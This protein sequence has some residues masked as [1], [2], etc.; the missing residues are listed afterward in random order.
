MKTLSKFT[1]LNYIGDIFEPHYS[2]RSV[3]IATYKVSRSKLDIKLKFSKVNESSEYAGYWFIP[4]KTVHKYRRKFDN[5]GLT[6]Y[7]V[8]MSEFEP[9]KIIE[10]DGNDIW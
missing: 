8:P 4:K 10:S 2:S 3:Y 7:V 6:C 1:Q 9:L 5:N